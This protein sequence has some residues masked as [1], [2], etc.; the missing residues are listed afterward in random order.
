MAG[1][2]GVMHGMGAG[3]RAAIGG[4]RYEGQVPYAP[5]PNQFVMSQPSQQ[6]PNMRSLV[7]QKD[8]HLDGGDIADRLRQAAATG[9]MQQGQGQGSSPLPT[10]R[11]PAM[12]NA[13]MAG[14]AE[15]TPTH[16]SGHAAP[17]STPPGLRGSIGGREL[18][19]TIEVGLGLGLD[20]GLQAGGGSPGSLDDVLGT[21]GLHGLNLKSLS[22][23][24]IWGAQASEG[25]PAAPRL[26]Q[27]SPPGRSLRGIWGNQGSSQMMGQ[28]QASPQAR[29]RPNTGSPRV[30]SI[31]RLGSD[32]GLG[33]GSGLGMG[34]M[35]GYQ[36]LAPAPGS[37]LLALYGTQNNFLASTSTDEERK[38]VG[39]QF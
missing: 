12:P 4:G 36:S 27:G 23:G 14:M 30:N 37:N 29:F 8:A 5:N 10:Y 34:T 33:P 39:S 13:V 35:P 11:M 24:H 16:I 21:N 25:I 19:P 26:Q 15:F 20:S 6:S 32:L 2:G 28:M 1:M 31:P 17:I 18:Q 22:L 38:D 7:P 9:V 3:M